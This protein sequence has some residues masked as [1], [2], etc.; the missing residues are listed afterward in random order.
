[1]KGSRWVSLP[2]WRRWWRGVSQV[3][4]RQ[5]I[6]KIVLQIWSRLRKEDLLAS[7]EGRGTLSSFCKSKY[8]AIFAAVRG[9]IYIYHVKSTLPV[10]DV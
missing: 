5:R 6:V 8:G 2:Y 10:N 9:F 3:G 4:C 1:M 7:S